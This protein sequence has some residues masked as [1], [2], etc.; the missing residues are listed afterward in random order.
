MTPT[1]PA[2]MLLFSTIMFVLRCRQLLQS[3]R[4]PA[5]G[6]VFVVQPRIE[7]ASLR[8]IGFDAELSSRSSNADSLGIIRRRGF[9]S[10][11][12]LGASNFLLLFLCGFLSFVRFV[13]DEIMTIQSCKTKFLLSYIR[14]YT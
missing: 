4:R 13:Q 14:D 6:I 2:Q 7:F 8:G 11:L 1:S 9:F 12:S 5:F 10:F 3:T